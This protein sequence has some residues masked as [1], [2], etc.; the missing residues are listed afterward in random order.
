LRWICRFE[1]EEAIP[2]DFRREALLRLP[3]RASAEPLV[4]KT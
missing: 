3:L 4:P 2:D 1:D